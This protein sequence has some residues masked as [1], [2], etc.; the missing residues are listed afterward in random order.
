MDLGMFSKAEKFGTVFVAEVF[1]LDGN[2]IL[3][4]YCTFLKL[5]NLSLS[6]SLGF[7]TLGFSLAFA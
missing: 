7:P 3:L 5:N 6:L 2:V 4:L 1:L